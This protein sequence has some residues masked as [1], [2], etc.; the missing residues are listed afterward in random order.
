M[1]RLLARL[2][3]DGWIARSPD[4]SNGARVIVQPSKQLVRSAEAL[5][6]AVRSAD[7]S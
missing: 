4:P 2:E 7:A 6:D 1:T 5:V 3:A